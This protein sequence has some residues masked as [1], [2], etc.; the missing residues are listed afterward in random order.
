MKIV[1]IEQGSFNSASDDLVVTLD[2]GTI[3]NISPEF[4]AINIFKNRHDFD[5]FDLAKAQVIDL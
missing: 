4:E 5:E 3:I 2:N 1:K